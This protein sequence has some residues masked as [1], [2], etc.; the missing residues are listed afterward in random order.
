VLPVDGMTQ[1]DTDGQHDD[2]KV[3][4]IPFKEEK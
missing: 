3:C 1:V 2:L 4:F